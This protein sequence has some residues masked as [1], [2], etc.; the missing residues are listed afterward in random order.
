MFVVRIFFMATTIG[1]RF[2]P[3]LT[4]TSRHVVAFKLRIVRLQR[5]F[6]ARSFVPSFAALSRLSR[7]VPHPAR[8]RALSPPRHQRSVDAT[9]NIDCWHPGPCSVAVVETIKA[10]V[11]SRPRQGRATHSAFEEYRGSHLLAYLVCINLAVVSRW[12]RR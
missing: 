11:V 7:R 5:R 6:F 9:G 3:G 12:T 8:Q 2:L 10:L 1:A 4:L